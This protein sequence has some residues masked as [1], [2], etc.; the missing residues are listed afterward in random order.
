MWQPLDDEVLLQNYARRRRSGTRYQVSD[1]RKLTAGRQQE[2]IC[3][4]KERGHDQDR[5]KQ[6]DIKLA[7]MVEQVPEFAE[8]R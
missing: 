8:D 5:A 2:E 7:T 4:G 3:R 6:K 1:I